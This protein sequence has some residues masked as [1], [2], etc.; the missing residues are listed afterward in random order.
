[1]ATCTWKGGDAGG[2][3]SPAIAAN[4]NEG[5]I[6]T[7]ADDVVFNATGDGYNCTLVADVNWGSLTFSSGYTKAFS[8]ANYGVTIQNASTLASGGSISLGS[9]A[10]YFKGAFNLTGVSSFSAG[11]SNIYFDG[12]ANATITSASKTLY[13]VN[14]NKAATY[15]MTL[16]DAMS[17]NT[18]GAT[19]KI[20]LNSKTLT[21]AGN[22]SM[23]G[24]LSHVLTGTIVL[25]GD[26]TL[27]GGYDFSYSGTLNGDF[28]GNNT[29]T[30]TSTT[31]IMFNSLTCAYAG[32]TT[33]WNSSFAQGCGSATLTVGSGTLQL[34]TDFYLTTT[35]SGAVSPITLTSTTPTITGNYCFIFYH[36]NANAGAVITLPKM[37]FTNTG[38]SSLSYRAGISVWFNKAYNSCTWILSD[39]FTCNNLSLLGY[40]TQLF[41]I[42]LTTGKILTCTG[43][44]GRQDANLGNSGFNYNQNG[45]TLNCTSFS[46]THP[47]GTNPFTF[48]WGTGTVNCSGSW[49]YD[50]YCSITV[51]TATINL[52]GTG[53]VTGAT[54]AWPTLVLGTTNIAT[55]RTWADGGCTIARLQVKSRT[56]VNWKAGTTYTISNYTSGDWNGNSTYKTIFQSTSAGTQYNFTNPASMTVSYM[57]VK[58]SIASNDIDAMDGTSTDSGNNVKWN[59]PSTISV[60]FEELEEEY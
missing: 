55:T 35:A 11:T 38:S 24:G 17:C 1:M 46:S 56:T 20:D 19:G 14:A 15:K 37:N 45:A 36:Y 23:N 59:F 31:I 5:S 13:T 25:T 52:T 27:T 57:N 43:F 34:N 53:T 6:P 26:G 22:C 60:F 48:D 21:V 29:I 39:D 12:S 47:V 30:M 40:G 32:K 49:T 33:I 3:T 42:T 10:C 44:F 54:K 2:T 58:D 50:T 41:T 9:S 8:T 7:S 4:W 28:Q 16:G 18:F 51:G